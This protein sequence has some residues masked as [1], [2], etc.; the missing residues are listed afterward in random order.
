M[1]AGATLALVSSIFILLSANSI[2]V[3]FFHSSSYTFL[4]ELLALDVPLAILISMLNSVLLGLQRFKQ[5]GLIGMTYVVLVYGSAIVLLKATNS[6][7]AVPIGWGIGYAFGA[8]LFLIELSRKH[9]RGNASRVDMR[10]IVSYSAPLYVTGVISV[11]AS[12]IDRLI[13]AYLKNLQS[14]GIYT[15]V[16]MIVAAVAILSSPVSSMVLSK[17]SEYYARNDSEMIREGV[18]ISTNAASV[19]YVP[20][21]LGVSALSIPFLRLVGGQAYVQGAIPLVI[22]L[23]VNSLFVIKGP[24]SSA[25]QGTRKTHIFVISASASLLV[26]FALSLVLIPQYSLVGAAAGYSSI[27]VVTFLIIYYFARRAEVLRLDLR[28][29]SRIWLSSIIMALT[30]Y[31]LAWL[32]GFTLALI[33][34]YVMSGLGWVLG[35]S[36]AMLDRPAHVGITFDSKTRQQ[37]DALLYSLREDVVLAPADSH[38][39]PH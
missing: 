31:A 26:N 27:P 7:E 33:P 23:V 14:I 4:V 16:L 5:S 8:A 20:A 17:F 10:R 32:T 37:T 36:G 18:R 9:V 35:N 13:V 38:N 30:V 29:L 24:L 2:S 28:M 11:G 19:L 3:L 12:Y 15:L 22:I 39:R 25:L 21:A 1:K 6:L 34:F